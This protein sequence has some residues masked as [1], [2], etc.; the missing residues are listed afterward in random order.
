MVKKSDGEQQQGKKPKKNTGE[1][2][3]L[4]VLLTSLRDGRIS[5]AD[6]N[7]NIVKDIEY[8]FRVVSRR[9][10][11]DSEHFIILDDESV[12]IRYSARGSNL[13]LVSL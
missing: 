12:E 3:E 2:S 9:D 6:E 4:Y 13:T 10:T 11:I 8:V 1:V 5:A 7:L